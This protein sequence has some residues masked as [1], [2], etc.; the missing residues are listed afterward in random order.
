MVYGKSQSFK[1]MRTGGTPILGHHHIYIN[2][3]IYIYQDP[4]FTMR[5]WLP[6]GYRMVGVARTVAVDGDFLGVLTSLRESGP[7][8]IIMIDA[9]MRGEPGPIRGVVRWAEAG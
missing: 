5:I 2:I 3:I 8:E 6:T 9:G 7:G 4:I 1:G